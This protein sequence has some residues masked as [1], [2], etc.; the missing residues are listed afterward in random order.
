M[1]WLLSV[2]D[3]L[4]RPIQ[5]AFLYILT[6][7]SEWER[8][9]GNRAISYPLRVRQMETAVGF[10]SSK[11]LSKERQ[12]ASLEKHKSL[13]HQQIYTILH[14]FESYQQLIRQITV[15]RSTKVTDIDDEHLL[16]F[17]KIWSRLV[18][19]SDDDHEQRQMISKRWTNIGFQV[20]YERQL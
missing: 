8:I 10:I 5:R 14:K 2:K 16:L 6:G 7:T 4:F 1:S 3:W 19:Q 9:V 17:D 18:I 20:G 11:L 12:A 13:V 15:L